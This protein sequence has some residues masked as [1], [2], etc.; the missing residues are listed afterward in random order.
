MYI[1]IIM[2]QFKRLKMICIKLQKTI[3]GVKIKIQIFTL[4]NAFTVQGK[5]NIED[6]FG[7]WMVAKIL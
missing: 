1:V 4:Y 3:Y 2:I 5:G 7:I 6:F